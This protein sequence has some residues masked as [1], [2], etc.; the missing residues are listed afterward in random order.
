MQPF[1][2]LKAETKQLGFAF[3]KTDLEAGIT[4]AEIALGASDQEKLDRNRENARKAA[5]A[6]KHFLARMQL[7][8]EERTELQGLQQKLAS[9]LHRLGETV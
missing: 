4:F 1:T 6:V 7:T 2:R 9:L 3:L 8:S 5:Q